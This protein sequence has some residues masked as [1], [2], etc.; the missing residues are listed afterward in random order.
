[1]V[2]KTTQSSTNSK[3]LVGQPILSQII[4]LLPKEAISKIVQS[5]KADRYYK[6]CSTMTH[7]IALIYGALSRCDSLREI[8]EG[9]LSYEGKLN[10][11]GLKK[12]PPRSTLSDANNHRSSRVFE[13]IYYLLVRRYHSF[14]S[15]SRLRGWCINGLKIIDST[16]I[17]LFSNIFQGSGRNPKNHSRKKGGLK[18]HML[19]DAD[20]E[21]AEF[22]RI[23][24]AKEHDKKFLED[25]HVPEK[26]LVVFDRAY[27]DYR[28]FARWD[29]KGIYFVT[30]MKKNA[31]YEMVERVEENN[32]EKLTKGVKKEERIKIKY[33]EEGK[34]Q[35]LELRRIEYQDDKGELYVFLSN[36]KA[37]KAE[38]I[39]E[40]YKRRWGIEIVFKKLKQNFPLKYG[41]F[42]LEV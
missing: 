22:V 34:E 5:H 11:L 2:K 31:V 17:T 8:C 14:L 30:R 21:A 7:L 28:L 4:R 37:L 13:D 6:S 1:M 15:D 42:H 33:K 9:L 10:H 3:N 12:A 27:N 29:K 25:L 39:A 36:N 32:L 24:S 40:V 18:V 23:T 19:I 16:T 38:E 35:E 26:S 41:R 20:K